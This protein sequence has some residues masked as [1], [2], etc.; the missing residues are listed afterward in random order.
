MAKN[1]NN[2][3]SDWFGNLF[4]FNGDGKTDISELWIAYNIFEECTKKENKPINYRPLHFASDI[5]LPKPD[6]HED[7]EDG[8]EYDLYPKDFDTKDEYS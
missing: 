3:S 8:S 4:D 6:W 7:C 2:R 5:A 1:T